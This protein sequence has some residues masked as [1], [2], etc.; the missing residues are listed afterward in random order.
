M[1]KN[2][3]TFKS[4][5]RFSSFTEAQTREAY[6]D[7]MLEDAGWQ[8][9]KHWVDEYHIDEMPNKSGYGKADY[10][11]FG[12]DGLP[13]AVIE[14]KRTSENVEKGRQQAVLYAD[15]LEKKFGQ[16]PIIFLTNGYET[17]IWS[18]KYYPERQVSGIYS[19]RDLEKEFNKMKDRKPLKCVQIKDEISSRCYQKEAIQSVCD[20]FGERNRRKAL[21]VMATGSGK[22]RTVIS[23]VDV[24]QRYSWVKNVLFLADRNALVTQ[25]KRAFHNL[26]PNLSLC[27]LAE[28]KA[29]IYARAVFSTYQTMINC[30]DDTRDEQGNRLFTPGHFDLIIVDEAHR[31]IYNKY[32][33][34]FT[35]FDA[36]LVGLTAT[37]KDE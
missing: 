13:L 10:V 31:S 3:K 17:R 28:N 22:T 33:D 12:D 5:P 7:V 16:R 14:A 20:A 29:D 27:N 21:L 25:A 34:I 11:M 23:I 8:R 18:D 6:I 19:K 26:M 2:H 35:Y 30:I 32:K 36:L 15:F 1:P 37:P 24:L 9:G 4:N